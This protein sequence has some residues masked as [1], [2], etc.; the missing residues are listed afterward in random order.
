MLFDMKNH[1]V[2]ITTAFPYGTGENFIEPEIEVVPMGVQIDI[3]PYHIPEKGI[4]RDV[5]NN[6][7]I[8]KECAVSQNLLSTA[9]FN[10]RGLFSHDFAVG[11]SELKGR[12]TL[13]L[14][15]MKRLVG[16]LGRS[17][18][19]A[20][21]LET[22]YKNELST[23]NLVLYSYWL[24][25]GAHAIAKLK[26]KYG[27]RLSVI[28]RAHRVDIYD[29][30]SVYGIIPVRS[31][32]IPN[33]DR[34]YVCSEEGRRYLCDRYQNDKNKFVCG[35]LGTQDLGYSVHDSRADEFVLLSCARITHVKRVHL[36]A[37]ALCRITDA[38]IHW[39][40]MGDGP[41]RHLV[42]REIENLPE[43]V[44]VTLMGTVPH[45]EVMQYYQKHKVDLFVNTSSSEGL[46][47]SIMEAISFGVP[48][49]ATNVGG[50]DEIMNELTGVLLPANFEVDKLAD[51]ILKYINMPSEHYMNARENA[52]K[53]WEKRF[54]ASKNYA[55]FYH[56]IT[57]R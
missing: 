4:C 28:S 3:A 46:P 2:L 19:I 38:K 6:I 27:E 18:E 34:I 11:V 5:P 20:E 53:Y 48:V 51:S 35:Y 30:Q 50:T 10:L 42:Q 47:V 31:E 13:S 54:S 45:T 16:Y 57:E 21:K 49:I 25:E 24:L 8:N 22:Y 32:M 23:G 39:I 43:N 26:R 12:N 40:H 55:E 52:R 36:L 37:Q 14:T 29:G 56:E 17:V 7:H 1:V 15:S 41:E 33:I 44:K 9:W